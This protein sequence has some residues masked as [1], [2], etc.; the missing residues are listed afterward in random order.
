MNTHLEAARWYTVSAAGTIHLPPSLSAAIHVASPSLCC[1]C[2]LTCHHLTLLIKPQVQR[3]G[4]R[5][6]PSLIFYIYFFQA[7]WSL[8]VSWMC[9]ALSVSLEFSVGKHEA[10]KLPRAPLENTTRLALT[11][12]GWLSVPCKHRA[13][14][15]PAN[16]GAHGGHT[17]VVRWQL[18]LRLYCVDIAGE[19]KRGGS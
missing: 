10:E 12:A 16:P 14:V 3:G 19:D 5:W 13:N 18:L 9:D 11:V 4:P 15:I 6:T 8:A 2:N 7:F 17:S 1:R